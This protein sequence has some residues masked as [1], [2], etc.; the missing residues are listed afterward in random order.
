MFS[1]KAGGASAALTGSRAE[2]TVETVEAASW[3]VDEA[4]DA[5]DEVASGA[6]DAAELMASG[7]DED[8]ADSFSGRV[9]SGGAS[10]GL[11]IENGHKLRFARPLCSM[12]PVTDSDD[13]GTTVLALAPYLAESDADDSYSPHQHI[14]AHPSPQTYSLTVRTPVLA[15]IGDRP[16]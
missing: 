9:S 7:G 11:G 14:K 1:R 3:R 8:A 4:C 12:Y 5:I 6:F 16:I 15:P 10:A 2:S 13:D